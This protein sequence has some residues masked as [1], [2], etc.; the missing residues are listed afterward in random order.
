MIRFLADENLPAPATRALREQGFEVVSVQERS[1]GLPDEEVICLGRELDA[2]ILTF[3]RDYGDLIF[4]DRMD[5]PPAVVFFR[6]KGEGVA[7]AARMLIELMAEKG[8]DPRGKFTVIT[9]AGVRER[10]Y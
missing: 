1:P 10:L 4:R 5:D 6:S 8:F 9:K 3:D 2:V 7:D